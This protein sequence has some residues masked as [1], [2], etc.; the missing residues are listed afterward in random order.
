MHCQGC[1]DSVHKKTQPPFPYD[2]PSLWWV[3]PRWV[4]TQVLAHMSVTP[5]CAP[6][7]GSGRRPYLAPKAVSQS[8]RRK[9]DAFTY[10]SGCLHSSSSP[11]WIVQTEVL[12][13]DTLLQPQEKNIMGW[14][15]THYKSVWRWQAL[16]ASQAPDSCQDLK[17]RALA[18][19][20]LRKEPGTWSALHWSH[21]G[22]ELHRPHSRVRPEVMS[23]SHSPA[24]VQPANPSWPRM[25][26]AGRGE[27]KRSLRWG[28]SEH[29]T[30]SS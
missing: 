17:G 28:G 27:E 4:P 23:D 5:P 15:C 10:A 19:W 20:A 12:S 25:F 1:L 9:T 11:D 22:D 16:P 29:P 8:K 13:L 26:Q 2:S 3:L 7:P 21:L 14:L 18:P 24:P 6:G 30:H